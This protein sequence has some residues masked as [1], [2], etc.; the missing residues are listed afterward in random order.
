MRWKKLQ[1]CPLLGLEEFSG[2]PVSVLR[3]G[4]RDITAWLYFV[5]G[6]RRLGNPDRSQLFAGRKIVALGPLRHFARLM[7]RASFGQFGWYGFALD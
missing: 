3:S 5:A 7:T 6:I 1:L 2:Q 4:R